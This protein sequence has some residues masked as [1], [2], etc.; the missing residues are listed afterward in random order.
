M[1]EQ[2][3]EPKGSMEEKGQ[4]GWEAV[5]MGMGKTE[6]LTETGKTCWQDDNLK[7]QSSGTG[8]WGEERGKH[9]DSQ[10]EERGAEANHKRDR[11][12]QK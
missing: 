5:E 12:S 2:E 6:R 7:L 9:R 3:E 10:L 11:D 8:G 4:G 1:N